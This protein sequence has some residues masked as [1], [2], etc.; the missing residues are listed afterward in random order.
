SRRVIEEI[1]KGIGEKLLALQLPWE[2]VRIY[3]DGLPLSGKELE[4]AREVAAQG[5]HNYRIVMELVRRGA[6]LMGTE[7]PELLTRE[8]AHI[9]GIAAARTDAD[10]EEARR[11]YAA[12]SAEILEKRDAFIARRIAE[13]LE[14]GEV[15]LLFLGMVHEVDRLLPEEIRVE[16]LIDRLPLREVEER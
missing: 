15:G 10:R 6:R 11:R 2:R 3:Q 16:F 1:W 9:K 4:I 5:S 7:S 12:E 14:E 13:T 8:Y